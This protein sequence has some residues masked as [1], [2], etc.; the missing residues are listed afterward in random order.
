MQRQA[1][2][3]FAFSALGFAL[4]VRMLQVGVEAWAGDS[5]SATFLIASLL[6]IALACIAAFY[7]WLAYLFKFRALAEVRRDEDL[8]LLLPAST[9]FSKQVTAS[10]VRVVRQIGEQF[11]RDESTPKFTLLRA[12]NKYWISLAEVTTCGRQDRGSA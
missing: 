12:A 10:H 8:Y 7:A 3:Y 9:S 1:I 6:G 5:L 4:S 11:S 2:I